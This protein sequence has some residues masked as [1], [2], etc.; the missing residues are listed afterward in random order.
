MTLTHSRCDVP[1]VHGSRYL[2]QLAK[3]WTHK[4]AVSFD[5]QHARIVMPEDRVI[6]LTH[7]D[8]RLEIRLTAPADAMAHLQNVTESH[9]ARFAF[10][11]ELVFDWQPA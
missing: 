11:E 6:A 1:T 7:H 8:D 3:H 4:F 9:I 2:Q 10:R 5:T